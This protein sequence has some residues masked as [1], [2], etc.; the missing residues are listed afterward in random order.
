[1]GLWPRRHEVWTDPIE[2][3]AQTL[4]VLIVM[5]RRR[6]NLGLNLDHY[7]RWKRHLSE[8]HG[9]REVAP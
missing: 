4:R 8:V 1:M 7:R 2:E 3:Q 5:A 9:A 6:P